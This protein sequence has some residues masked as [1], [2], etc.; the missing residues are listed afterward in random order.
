MIP[1]LSED[2]RLFLI[3]K[4]QNGEPL[5]AD[6]KYKLFPTLQREY[7]LVYAGKMRKEDLLADEDG[8]TAMPLQVE[9]VFNGTRE[10][11]ADG[12]RN[13]MVF[14]DNLQFLKT[15]YANTDELI[16]DRVK[17]QVKLIYIDP[18]FAT[19]SDFNSKTGQLAYTDKAKGSDFVEFLRRRL[20]VAKEILASDGTIY[21]HLDVKKGHTIKLL[22]DEVFTGFQFAEIVWVCGL[23]GSGKFFPKAHETIYCYKAPNAAFNPPPR[24]GYSKRITNALVK[25][26]NGW[27]YTRGRESSGGSNY[28]KTYICKNPNLTKEEAIEEANKNR[29]QT[30]WDVWIG[31]DEIAEAFND[32]PVGTY[33]FVEQ[34]STGYPTQKPEELLK[35]IIEASTN[36]NDIVFDFFGGSGTTAAVAEKLGRRW[37]TCDIGKLSFYTMQK[38][39]LQIQNSKSLT[40]PK[41]KHG[42]PARTFATVNAGLYDIA[43][44]NQLDRDNYR[45]F[46]LNLFEIDPKSQH[47][48]GIR[49]DG[50]R[51]GYY[52]MIWNFWDFKES[53]VDEDF[54][55]DLHSSLRGRVGNRFYI[56][57]PA[58]QVGFIAD[59]HEIEGVRYY[60]LKVPY[61]IIQELHKKEFARFRQPQSKSKI[62]DLSDAVGFHFMRQPKVESRL[63]GSE[64]IISHFTSL[65]SEEGTGR[66][67]ANFESLSMVLWDAD[68]NGSEF[69][70]TGSVFAADLIASRKQKQ[71]DLEK[72]ESEGGNLF[73]EQLRQE[74]TNQTDLRIPLTSVGAR[75][76]VVFIDIYGNEFKIEFKPVQ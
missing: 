24:L 8:T 14:G 21:V 66:D 38:R 55:N 3:D 56:I 61:Q 7:E 32:Y 44:L 74:L 47:I 54:L 17:G 72:A 50:Q 18:P 69:L 40:N 19:D 58:N 64:L 26:E 63:E 51:F 48:N 2:E 76:A 49:V 9:K 67:M 46:V 4:L 33:A 75:V 59:Y 31:K 30:A 12:W 43:K 22:L 15:L 45:A 71:K 11:F 34:D 62:N 16:R 29:P 35:R 5:P 1:Q 37:I 52:A 42:I 6:F 65:Y 13:L 36:L 70:M 73:V 57:A 68:Y 27:F 53:E 23:M 20:I 41:Q 25:D 39:L 28:L 10:G 60:F